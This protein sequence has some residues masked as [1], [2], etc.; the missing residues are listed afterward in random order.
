[1]TENH[2]YYLNH[3]L[4]STTSLIDYYPFYIKSM[5]NNS[6]R[7]NALSFVLIAISVFF[8]A[9]ESEQSIVYKQ[10]DDVNN[11]QFDYDAKTLSWG[12]V[13]NANEYLFYID[14]NTEN[15]F[16][17][18]KTTKTHYT[19]TNDEWV[20]FEHV[21]FLVK[22]S[23]YTSNGVQY[24]TSTLFGGYDWYLYLF[25]EKWGGW[26]IVKEPS[27]IFYNRETGKLT[28][29][30]SK[31]ENDIGYSFLEPDYFVV[32]YTLPKQSEITIPQQITSK[33][34]NFDDLF[35]IIENDNPINATPIKFTIQAHTNN[36]RIRIP[37]EKEY[38]SYLPLDKPVILTDYQLKVDSDGRLGGSISWNKVPN[39]RGYYISVY[40][41]YTDTNHFD[42]LA[43]TLI[44]YHEQPIKDGFVG[45][46]S[47]I[48]SYSYSVQV[49]H[50]DVYK[51]VQLFYFTIEAVAL[52]DVWASSTYDSR[53]P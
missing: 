41:K 24:L 40:F 50:P 52:D 15:G 29:D 8:V 49:T 27:N 47:L 36:F 22:A 13:E 32:K 4:L 53:N 44:K 28:W 46:S 19:Y 42:K 25:D 2:D 26:Y 18:K 45:V 10:L 20:N 51:K 5:Y 38:K 1:L 7:K 9:C 31:F 35:K 21:K 11:V 3:I 14:N 48:D 30:T 16:L 39:A 33:E 43:A 6:M 23:G 12:A 34:Y 37:D 17:P